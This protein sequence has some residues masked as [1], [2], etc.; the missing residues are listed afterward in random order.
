MHVR[1]HSEPRGESKTPLK[2]YSTL[3]S[4]IEVSQTNKAVKPYWLLYVSVGTEKFSSNTIK[5]LIFET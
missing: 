5:E 4:K 1:G 2:E 3:L